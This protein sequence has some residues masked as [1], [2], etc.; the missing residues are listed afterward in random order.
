MALPFVTRSV[1]IAYGEI[2]IQFEL[3]TGYILTGAGD[4]PKPGCFSV[5]NFILCVNAQRLRSD[6]VS[7]L[8]NL[9]QRLTI[10]C[11]GEPNMKVPTVCQTFTCECLG[12]TK[13]R[14]QLV[15][16]TRH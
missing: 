5:R 14:L 6:I 4:K 1:P 2:H 15:A 7:N 12:F 13:F 11:S 16:W 8:V 9:G 3:V 10:V